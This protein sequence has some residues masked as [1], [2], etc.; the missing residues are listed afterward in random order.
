VSLEVV[1]VDPIQSLGG[2]V[3][4]VK[5]ICG[6]ITP[7]DQT[8]PLLP[9]TYETAINILNPGDSEAEFTK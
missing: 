3:Y 7:R 1:P 5:F 6:V 2:F 9:G 8:P 4:A